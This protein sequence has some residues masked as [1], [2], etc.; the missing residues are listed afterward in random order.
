MKATCDDQVDF[1]KVT[2]SEKIIVHPFPEV[3]K[4]S[5]VTTAVRYNGPSSQAVMNMLE[6]ASGNVEPAKNV[7]RIDIQGIESGMAT[8]PIFN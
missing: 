4:V 6:A 1:Y 7:T 8:W 3:G 2:Y 5:F